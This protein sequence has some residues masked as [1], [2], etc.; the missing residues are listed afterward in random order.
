MVVLPMLGR[1]VVIA[2]GPRAMCDVLA[3]RPELYRRI[4]AG[5]RTFGAL[6]GRGVAASE[7]QA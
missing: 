3:T 2:A 4:A 7:G 1:D 5:D 6:I